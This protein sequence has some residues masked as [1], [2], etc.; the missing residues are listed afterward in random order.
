MTVAGTLKALGLMILIPASIV[1]LWYGLAFIVV[2]VPRLKLIGL[3]MFVV[4]FRAIILA[5]DLMWG[6]PAVW[7]KDPLQRQ[8]ARAPERFRHH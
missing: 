6:R 2:G 3:V 8:S 1:T 4:A 7:S 5:F